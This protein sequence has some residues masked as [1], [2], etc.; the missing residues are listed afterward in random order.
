MKNFKEYLAEA[1]TDTYKDLVA[2]VKSIGY[3]KIKPQSSKRFAVLV[4]GNRINAMQ[5]LLAAINQKYP[6]AIW[7]EN[8]GS[9][10]IG[11]IVVDGDHLVSV[12]P[13]SKQGK[14]SAG[15]QNE[16]TL[17]NMIGEIT[18]NGPMTIVFRSESGD[19]E[20]EDVVGYRDAG[21][22]TAGRKKADITII[23]EDGKEIPISLKKDGAEMWESADSYWATKAK[24][25]IDA[26]IKKKKV[27]LVPLRNVYQV[28]PNLAVKADKKEVKNVVFGSDILG[29]G[30]VLIKTFKGGFKLEED[31]A[32]IE[33]TKIIKKESELKGNYEIYF[34]IRNDSSR[35]G[36]K[37]YPGIRVLAVNKT[38]INKNVLVVK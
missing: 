3:K 9:S 26:L 21:R 19:F 20:I 4:D 30:C 10:S 14:A 38:R 28:K 22:D 33:V 25:V 7:D 17:F 11:G 37:I 23:K 2:L 15:L 31:K 34:L 35:K 8:A 32:I 6:K 36:S 29:K 12:S 27:E 1:V 5:A 24:S 13:A 18:K 16:H